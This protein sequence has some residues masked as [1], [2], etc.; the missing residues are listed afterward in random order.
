MIA[1]AVTATALMIMIAAMI[2]KGGA[3]E[4][5]TRKRAANTKRV[6]GVMILIVT[7]AMRM[8][9]RGRRSTNER[10]LN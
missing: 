7:T 8:T 3:N 10:R 1:T 5:S 9:R 2:V 4:R 6:H